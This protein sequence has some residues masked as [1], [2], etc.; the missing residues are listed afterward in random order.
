MSAQ[1]TIFRTR[2]LVLFGSKS[3]YRLAFDLLQNNKKERCI[4]MR[5]TGSEQLVRRKL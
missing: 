3:T 4:N 1:G 2:L 5:Y